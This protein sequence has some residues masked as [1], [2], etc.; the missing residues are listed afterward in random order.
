MNL[1]KLFE[2]VIIIVIGFALSGH[3]DSLTRWV[4]RAQAKL[5]YESRAS[6][7][8]S[9]SAFKQNGCLG[10]DVYNKEHAHEAR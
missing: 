6:G 4:Y 5:I 8:G 1:D 7:W 3:L 2:W 10:C 9:P